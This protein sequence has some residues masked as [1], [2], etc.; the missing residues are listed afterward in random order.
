MVNAIR[1]CTKVGIMVSEEIPEAII[2]DAPQAKYAVSFDPL[3]GSS[4]IDCNVSVGTIFGIW[5]RV[6]D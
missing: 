5:R 6:T 1:F 3:D 4:N 2:C